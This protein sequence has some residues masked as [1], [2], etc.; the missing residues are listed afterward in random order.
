MCALKGVSQKPKV[1]R[2]IFIIILVPKAKRIYQHPVLLILLT[3]ASD[4]SSDGQRDPPGR[5]ARGMQVETWPLLA[6]IPTV[7]CTTRDEADS[8][9]Q[10]DTTQWTQAGPGR[11]LGPDTGF[12][13]PWGHLGRG[14]EAQSPFSKVY[15][16]NARMSLSQETRRRD[17][18]NRVGE[19]RV[20]E[21][22]AWNCGAI[23]AHTRMRPHACPVPTEA[24]WGLTLAVVLVPC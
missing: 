9:Q 22:G 7:A 2:C 1:T 11:R 18:R 3:S 19:C 17:P 10:R 20:G 5:V 8:A 21:P 4:A 24:L 6:L 12:T 23:P 15:A 13:Q 16:G 14:V